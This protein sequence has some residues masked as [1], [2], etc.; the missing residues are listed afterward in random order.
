[1]W[2]KPCEALAER[3]IQKT[4]KH[5]GGNVMV[6]G[7]FAWSVVGSLARIHGI[8]TAVDY[9]NILQ[10]NLEISLLKCGL[11]GRYLFQQDNDPKHTAKISAAFFKANRIKQLEWPPQSPDL[12]PIENLWSYLDSKINKTN[13]TNKDSY[14]GALE[15][16]WDNIDP[17]YLKSLVE[18]VP[19][20]LAAVLKAKGGH[21]KY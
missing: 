6:W 19:R 17:E 14:F 10:E 11:E 13:V 20:R 7:S 16:A 9:I 12:N 8:M 4:V 5:G 15:E 1:V 3:N 18:S 21:T 2:R